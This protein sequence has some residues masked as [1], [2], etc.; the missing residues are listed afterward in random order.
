MRT[1]YNNLFYALASHEAKEAG[2]G[3]AANRRKECLALAKE[4]AL[5]LAN[6]RSDRQTNID[7]V[8]QELWKLGYNPAELGNA[9]GSVFK[10]NH[11]IFTG[12]WTNSTRISSHARAVRI[13]ELR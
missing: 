12:K 3:L 10:T 8:Q 1:G 6:E 9:A 13:W 4:L 2:M 7:E 5:K 11:W